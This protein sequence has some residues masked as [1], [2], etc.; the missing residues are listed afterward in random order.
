MAIV[1]LERLFGPIRQS[2]QVTGTAEYHVL[3]DL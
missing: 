2:G 3:A 1:K